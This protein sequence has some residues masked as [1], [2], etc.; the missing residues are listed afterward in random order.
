MIY[1]EK[2]RQCLKNE[3][4]AINKM[5]LNDLFI[6]WDKVENAVNKATDSKIAI[7]TNAISE[8]TK[9]ITIPRFK[10]TPTRKCGFI[11]D[12]DVFKPYYLQ[13][14]VALMLDEAGVTEKDKGVVIKVRPYC[15]G[16]FLQHSSYDILSQKHA[17][18]WQ[19]H[20]SQFTILYDIPV[21]AKKFK[22]KRPPVMDFE[23]FMNNSGF[24]E[25]WVTIL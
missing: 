3:T 12:H 5:Y 18:T 10:Y 14:I 24:D 22:I 9:Y 1:G 6:N 2:L 15:T 21:S 16:F 20:G 17:F 13:D 23:K 11:E 19:P 7:L 4:N 8:Y 25:S